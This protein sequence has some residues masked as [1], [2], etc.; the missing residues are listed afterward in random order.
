MG[1]LG[2]RIA[3]TP[4]IIRARQDTAQVDPT[5][6]YRV[7]QKEQQLNDSLVNP[8]GGYT[9]P[10]IRDA[11]RRSGQRELMQQGGEQAR[12]GQYDVNRLNQSRNLAL[13]GL[14]RGY[15]QTYSSTGTGKVVQS[16][17]LGAIGSVAGAA[18]QLGPLSLGGA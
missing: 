2:Q 16:D 8:L 6:G 18:G 7:A 10:A 1:A 13:A 12:E 15:D 17:P 4:D 3:D 14:T 11:I 9:T 5:I